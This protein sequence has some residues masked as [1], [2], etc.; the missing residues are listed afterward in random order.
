MT[1]RD[2]WHH[3][4]E[5]IGQSQSDDSVTMVG[6]L[7]VNALIMLLS[8]ML[9][10][11]LIIWPIHTTYAPTN[12][13]TSPLHSCLMTHDHKYDIMEL[14]VVKPPSRLSISTTRIAPRKNM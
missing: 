11:V 14:G 4:N 8:V 10:V 5:V 13:T 7:S 9:L 1:I 12:V 3:Y 2:R 6:S